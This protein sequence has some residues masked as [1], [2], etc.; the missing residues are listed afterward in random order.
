MP[1]TRRFI[2]L[3]SLLA[4][5]SPLALTGCDTN[6]Q[7]E[8]RFAGTWSFTRITTDGADVTD[9]V[10]ARYEQLILTFV[11]DEDRFVLFGDVE[12][13]AEDLRLEGFFSVSESSDALRLEFDSV[14]DAFLFVS[15]DFQFLG[16]DEVRLV[17]EDGDAIVMSTLLDI[18]F[19]DVEE[20]R[21]I[22]MR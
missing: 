4:L 2:L 13:T 18:D 12:G 6:D 8:E 7:G 20:V 19:G 15:L 17:A 5:W 9:L 22:L 11:P 21:I 1:I 3:A 16:T 14:D 10:L